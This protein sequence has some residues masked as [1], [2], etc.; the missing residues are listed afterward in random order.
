[1]DNIHLCEL[2]LRAYEP[3]EVSGVRKLKAFRG[4]TVDLRLRQFRKIPYGKRPEFIEFTSTKGQR[5]LAQMHQEAVQQAR[6]NLEE[7]VK[8]LDA[9]FEKFLERV[10]QEKVTR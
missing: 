5:L 6:K 3:E 1:M 8:R 9:S 10:M 4:Y 7:L 2:C